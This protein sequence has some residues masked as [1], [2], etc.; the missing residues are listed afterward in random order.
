MTTNKETNLNENNMPTK[1]G[2]TN[3]F[4]KINAIIETAFKFLD[5]GEMIDLSA[6]EEKISQACRNITNL[7]DKDQKELL[8]I[9]EDIL[10]KMDKLGSSLVDK[11]SWLSGGNE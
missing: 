6:M 8:P 2:M 4:E 10:V 3:E 1:Q 7:S 9:M 5:A 11:Y